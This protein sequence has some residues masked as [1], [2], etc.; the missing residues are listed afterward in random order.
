MSCLAASVKFE[1]ELV[2]LAAQIAEGGLRAFLHHVAER[3]GEQEATLAG[4]ARDL[5]EEDFAAHRRPG[6]PGGD[7]EFGDFLRRFR[8]E[9]R[10]AQLG[11]E[12]FGFELDR[13]RRGRWC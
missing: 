7:A 4:H 3:A 5:D 13:A 12:R 10:M 6:Q 9:R 1:A 11:F 2:G 8:D